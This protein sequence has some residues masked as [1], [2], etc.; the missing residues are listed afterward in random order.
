MAEDSD[1]SLITV[2]PQEVTCEERSGVNLPK[3][4][5]S[6]GALDNILRVDINS[7]YIHSIL[8]VNVTLRTEKHSPGN[9]HEA[10]AKLQID[11]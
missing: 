5:E 9:S 6:S 2:L 8:E 10:L 1:T 7:I 3:V 11:R 4:I